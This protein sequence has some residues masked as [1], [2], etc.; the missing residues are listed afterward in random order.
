MS[1]D[2][3]ATPAQAAPT[4]DMMTMMMQMMQQQTQLM[5]QM[6]QEKPLWK[7]TKNPQDLEAGLNALRN[8][9]KRER[10]T[11]KKGEEEYDPI[12]EDEIKSTA[13]TRTLQAEREQDDFLPK[14]QRL[15]VL[16]FFTVPALRSMRNW[17]GRVPMGSNRREL[18]MS[19]ILLVKTKAELMDFILSSCPDEI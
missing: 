14:S 15:Y 7:P 6:Q 5:Q 11:M 1:Q 17:K 2:Q 9:Y 3:P 13:S 18:L 4:P 19:A 10:M 16:K 8:D 12:E